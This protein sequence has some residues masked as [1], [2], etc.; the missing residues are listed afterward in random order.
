MT[1]AAFTLL[2]LFSFIIIIIIIIIH[3]ANKS[4]DALHRT[5]LWL[6]SSDVISLPTSLFVSPFSDVNLSKHKLLCPEDVKLE[7]NC[8]TLT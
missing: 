1:Q 2:A 4:H 7:L 3:N 5:T 8:L 6:T